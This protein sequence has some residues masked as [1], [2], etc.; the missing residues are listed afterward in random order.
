MCG[1]SYKS[2]PVKTGQTRVVD[3]PLIECN[4]YSMVQCSESASF[5]TVPVHTGG[6][7]PAW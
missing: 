7:P 2:G 5:C 3:T 6:Q 4:I 1:V